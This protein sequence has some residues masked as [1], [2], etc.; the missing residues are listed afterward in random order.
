MP[1]GLRPRHDGGERS[2]GGNAVEVETFRLE[3][4][5]VHGVLPGNIVGAIANEAGLDGKHIGHIDIRE[6]HSYVDLPAGMPKEIFRELK[7]VKIR[8]EELR[9]SRVDSKPPRPERTGFRSRPEGGDRDFRPRAP[10][11]RPF[12]RREFGGDNAP[13]SREGSSAGD[14]PPTRREFGS[15]DT[16]PPRRQFGAG[17]RPPT[18]P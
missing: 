1:I 11:S 16:R 12:K 6:D 10:G 15:D 9:I 13:P 3:V 5:H 18:T 17:D 7:K 8:G 14:A 4:G 2:K